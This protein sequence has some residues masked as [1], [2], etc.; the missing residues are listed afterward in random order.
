MKRFSVV[1]ALLFF[2]FSQW[3]WAAPNDV[4]I[5]GDSIF[6]E[7]GEIRNHLNRTTPLN[8]QNY[9]VGGSYMDD[10]ITQYSKARANGIPRTIIMNG[11]GN[12]ILRGAPQSCRAFDDRCIEIIDTSVEKAE[13]LWQSMAND[14][15]ENVIYLGY[16]Y[17]KRMGAGLDKS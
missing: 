4:I 15:V 9:A 7:S 14:G 2:A 17:T 3:A 10:V 6:T 16:Y 8:I 5:L 11:G 12:D 1:T 13:G